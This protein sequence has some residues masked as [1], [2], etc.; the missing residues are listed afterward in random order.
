[1]RNVVGIE[2]RSLGRLLETSAAHHAD[3]HPRDDQNG[4]ATERRRR[5]SVLGTDIH[6]ARQIRHQMLGNANRANARTATAMRDAEGL[7]QVHVTDVSA[8]VARTG[9]PNQRIEVRTVEIDLTA[10]FMDDFAERLDAFFEHA[11]GRRIG[12][13]E[14][15]EII[16]MLLGLGFQIVDVDIAIWTA[17]DHDN[18]HASHRGAGRIGA[19]CRRWNKADVAMT[20]APRL[21]IVANCQQTSIFALATCIWL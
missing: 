7:V 6:M 5:N 16:T 8:N 15:S 13:H 1:M 20:F 4:C 14:G 21:V 12:D 3:I 19:M 10:I 2:D 18:A 11:I 17:I 9:E